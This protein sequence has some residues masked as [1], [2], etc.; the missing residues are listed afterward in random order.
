MKKLLSGFVISFFSSIDPLRVRMRVR[1]R[2]KIFQLTRT[3]TAIDAMKS[4]QMTT[5]LKCRQPR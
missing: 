3:R 4:K 1:I 2:E 5:Q